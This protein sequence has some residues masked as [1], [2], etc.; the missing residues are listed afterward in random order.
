MRNRTARNA[1]IVIV[2]ALTEALAVGSALSRYNKPILA[3]CFSEIKGN[4]G[5]S[6]LDRVYRYKLLYGSALP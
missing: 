6:D 5:V 4:R 3:S 1:V 2:T